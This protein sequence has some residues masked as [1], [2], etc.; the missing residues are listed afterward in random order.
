MNFDDY[1]LNYKVIN[2][3]HVNELMLIRHLHSIHL[4]KQNNCKYDANEKEQKR[5]YVHTIDRNT[6]EPASFVVVVQGPLQVVF[7]SFS[8]PWL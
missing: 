2:Y 6:G 1:M 3:F 8:V 4:L 7:M 5:L